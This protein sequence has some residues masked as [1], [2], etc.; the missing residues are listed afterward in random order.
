[1]STEPAAERP[2]LAQLAGYFLTLGT[3]GLGGPARR[4]NPIATARL[5]SVASFLRSDMVP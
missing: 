4:C 2:T 3:V 1:M 5:S